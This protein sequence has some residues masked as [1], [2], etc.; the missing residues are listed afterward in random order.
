[1]GENESGPLDLWITR[2]ATYIVHTYT[3]HS[4][5]R[6]HMVYTMQTSHYARTL[7]ISLIIQK[8]LCG[9][10]QNDNSKEIMQNKN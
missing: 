5:I 6:E 1:M 7:L 2:L 10:I 8:K 3:L 9:K 4:S